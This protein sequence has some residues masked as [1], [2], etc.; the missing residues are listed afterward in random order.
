MRTV[1]VITLLLSF[2]LYANSIQETCE[3]SLLHYFGSEAKLKFSY[4]PIPPA[5]KLGIEQTARQRFFKDKIYYWKISDHD[6]TVALAALDNVMGKAM[7][8]TILVIFDKQGRILKS[9]IVKYRESI[10]GEVSNSRWLKQFIGLSQ[11]DFLDPKTRIDGISGA[12][13][14]VQSVSKGVKK[15]SLLFSEIK[16]HAQELNN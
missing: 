2:G 5:L 11:A 15:L 13:I 7:P 12:T 8:I 9:E 16:K 6:S 4:F 3:A 1:I 14:S 10:G